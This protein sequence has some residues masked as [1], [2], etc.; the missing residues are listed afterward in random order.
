M[1]SVAVTMKI[2]PD[3]AERDMN[4]L[5]DDLT[6]ALPAGAKMLGMQVKPIAFGLKA[7]LVYFTVGDEEGGSEAV[8]AAFA[9]VEGVESIT[10]ENLDRTF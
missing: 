5:Q 3:G 2:M 9:K 1:G 6:K 4:K 8:E 10:I 7:L